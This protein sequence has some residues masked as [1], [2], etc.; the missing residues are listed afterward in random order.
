MIFL[1]LVVDKMRIYTRYLSAVI[2]LMTSGCI[3]L[4][5]ERLFCPEDEYSKLKCRAGEIRP[6]LREVN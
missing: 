5:L 1:T 4:T 2:I 3:L 6:E